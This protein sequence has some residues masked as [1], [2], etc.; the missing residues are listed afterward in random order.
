MLS[1]KLPQLKIF[2]L[3]HFEHSD[4]ACSKTVVKKEGQK[5]LRGLFICEILKDTKKFAGLTTLFFEYAC[6]L[7]DFV[8]SEMRQQ[9]IRQEDLL[10][11]FDHSQRS[12][13]HNINMEGNFS[14]EKL[15]SEIQNG[16]GDLLFHYADM[17]NA[18]DSDASNNEYNM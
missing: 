12:I 7:T 9:G 3:G 6:D 11:K 4:Y 17:D 14:I 5:P 13:D 10:I 1:W 2:H 8:I 15:N 16:D 18:Y